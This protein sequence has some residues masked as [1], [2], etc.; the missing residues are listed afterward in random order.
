MATAPK[1]KPKANGG[2]PQKVQFTHVEKVMFPEAGVTKGEVIEFY[3]KIA[4]WL[5]PHLRDR[6]VTLERLP[7]GVGEGK[8]RFWQ[9]NTPPYYP[10]WIPRIDIPTE[11]G[12]S[13]Q[14]VLVNDV[15]TLAYLVNQGT[16]TF[17]PYLSRVQNLD[18]PDFVLFDLD[19]GGAK[20][21]DVV[22]IANTLQ[23]ILK[24]DGVKSFPKTSGKS[25]LHVMVPWKDQGGF[26]AARAWAVD[27]AKRLVGK[28]PDLATTERF[29]SEREGRVYVDVIQNGWGKHAV[30]PYVLRAT[31]GATVSTPLEWKE[32]TPK[33]DPRQFNVR[34]IFKRLGRRSDPLK[35][36][37]GTD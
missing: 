31:P 34:T 36:L 9:K 4:R 37:T 18:R 8:P 12:K 2:E 11:A 10:K 14:Y 3:I 24:A 22:T 21:A 27:V 30:P 28:L 13:V 6:P 15:E 33:L 20:F 25:G 17:H 1:S 32:V 5:L 29:K 23:T 19:P 26:D 7:D 16:I 35:P